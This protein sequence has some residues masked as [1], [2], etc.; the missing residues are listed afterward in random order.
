MT[1]KEYNSSVS[2][3]ADYLYRFA[4]KSTRNEADAQDIVQSAFEK[5]W[6]NRD[7]V[8]AASC[9][10][11]LFTVAYR[12]MIDSHRKSNRVVLKD[13]IDEN[14]KTTDNIPSYETKEI[15]NHALYRLNEVQRNLI[16]L[17]D[18][19]GY[20]YK[21]IAEIT[22]LNISQVKVYLHRARLQLRNYLI[23]PQNVI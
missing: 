4:L 11:Y 17:K 15:L 10:S 22:S 8:N 12:Q 16:L 5:L 9:K 1:K 19:E 21:E 3:F 13:K 7:K 18:Y 6:K 2:D 14:E 20:S 23:K